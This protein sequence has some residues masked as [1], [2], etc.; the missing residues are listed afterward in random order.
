MASRIETR[1]RELNLI[2]PEAGR[3]VANFVP[4]VQA[5]SLLFVSGQI[6]TWNDQLRHVGQVGALRCLSR[7]PAQARSCVR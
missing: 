3:P 6:T 2:L 1:L 7:K 5:G 4:C